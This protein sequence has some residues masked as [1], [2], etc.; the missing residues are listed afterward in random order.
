MTDPYFLRYRWPDPAAL[1]AEI[2]EARA[3][4]IA[5]RNAN[6]TAGEADNACRLAIALTAA[7]RE[8]EAAVLLEEVLPKVRATGDHASI[9]LTLLY[10]ATARQYLGEHPRAQAMFAEALGIATVHGFRDLEHYVWHHRGRCFAEMRNFRDARD[11]FE[12]AL[13]LRLELAD[14][15]AERSRQALA[16]LDELAK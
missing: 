8:A 16:L 13:K 6:N 14:P 7:D 1:A 10:L 11:C 4:L 9:G 5:A 3:E 15:R 12:R 2:A